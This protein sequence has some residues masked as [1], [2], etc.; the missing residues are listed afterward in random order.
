ME[1]LNILW[2]T[3]NKDTIINM[4]SMYSVNAI[5]Y[6]WWNEINII[7][8]GGS[9]KLIN[10]DK[11]IQ[12]EVRKMIEVGVNIEGCLACSDKYNATVTLTGLGIDLKYMGEPL[13]TY[14][15]NDEKI[16]TL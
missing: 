14:L 7:V 5:K 1:K 15:K 16:I 2:T 4:I 8:W 6:G 11:E 10:E 9:A 13:T 12:E 3:T